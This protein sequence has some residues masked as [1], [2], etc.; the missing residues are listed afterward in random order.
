MQLD[1]QPLA[2][3][4]CFA[5][6][7]ARSLLRVWQHTEMRHSVAAE[8]RVALLSARAMAWRCAGPVAP[9]LVRRSQPGRSSYA[10]QYGLDMAR[11]PKRPTAC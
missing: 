11:L 6:S 7:M 9:P 2:L 10:Y 8:L 5:E 3:L 1:Y 4:L